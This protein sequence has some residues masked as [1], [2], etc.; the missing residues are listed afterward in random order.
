[1]LWE[2]PQGQGRRCW[3]VFKPRF[4]GWDTGKE[5]ERGIVEQGELGAEE[6]VKTGRRKE[7]ALI[8]HVF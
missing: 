4:P 2:G 5:K 7:G 3:G 1:M 8:F 6:R